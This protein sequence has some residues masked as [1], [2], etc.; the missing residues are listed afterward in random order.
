MHY[1]RVAEPPKVP[2][3]DDARPDAVQKPRLKRCLLS[4]LSPSCDI[5]ESN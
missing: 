1:F 2:K 3:F 5:Q 4:R